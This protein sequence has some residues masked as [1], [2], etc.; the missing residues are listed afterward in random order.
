MNTPTIQS[1][2][3]QGQQSNAGAGQS[4]PKPNPNANGSQGADG[5][6]EIAVLKQQLAA[7]SS[8]NERLTGLVSQRDQHSQK[9]TELLT[10]LEAD[11]DRLAKKA[12]DNETKLLAMS[13]QKKH[14]LTPDQIDNLGGSENLPAYRQLINGETAALRSE[15]AELKQ[16]LSKPAEGQGGNNLKPEQLAEIAMTHGQ[17]GALMQTPLVQLIEQH[18]NRDEMLNAES[19]EVPGRTRKEM[20]DWWTAQ[21]NPQAKLRQYELIAKEND[22]A[23]DAGTNPMIPPGNGLTGGAPVSQ[24]EFARDSL[25][26]QDNILEKIQSGEVEHD[27]VDKARNARHAV[28]REQ[29]GIKVEGP[30]TVHYIE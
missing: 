14:E 29:S 20:I 15:I 30:Q 24:P 2:F 1:A 12:E 25:D 7:L 10:R 28:V 6:D 5:T 18:P 21:G 8:A 19:T 22:L 17:M 3:Q 16:Q 9:T 11:N 27:D 23:L 26:Q 13:E 4:F